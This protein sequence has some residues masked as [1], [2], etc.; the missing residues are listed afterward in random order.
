MKAVDFRKFFFDLIFSLR[1]MELKA[2][3]ELYL[4]QYRNE[5]QN[6]NGL[7]IMQ[8]VSRPHLVNSRMVIGDPLRALCCCFSIDTG[9]ILAQGSP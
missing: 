3:L 9:R 7:Y 2:L 6:N 1:S 4:I 5:R 8:L